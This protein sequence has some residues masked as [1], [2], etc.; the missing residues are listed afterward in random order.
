MRRAGGQLSTSLMDR[1]GLRVPSAIGDPLATSF[2]A[3]VSADA[4][5]DTGSTVSFARLDFLTRLNAPIVGRCESKLST[6]GLT[7]EQP[8]R[9]AIRIH[10]PQCARL[11]HIVWPVLGV[12][13]GEQLPDIVLGLDFIRNVRLSI[14]SS[15]DA[16]SI[17][18]DANRWE[19]I[20]A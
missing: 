15:D 11:P 8:D 7:G 12:A 19:I 14:S 9:Y 3:D 20:A 10:F 16:W 13:M 17:L 4:L 5:I 2:A 6:L 18:A 1:V